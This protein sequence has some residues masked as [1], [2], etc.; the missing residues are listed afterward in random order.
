[1]LQSPAFSNQLLG[2]RDFVVLFPQGWGRWGNG[3]KSELLHTENWWWKWGYF[4]EFGG[5]KELPLELVQF[6]WEF[7][8][9]WWVV[10]MV[11][12]QQDE[13]RRSQTYSFNNNFLERTSGIT[14]EDNS[15]S[16]VPSCDVLGFH[17]ECLAK[18]IYHTISCNGSSHRIQ[19]ALRW[20][21][22]PFLPFSSSK[23]EK[24]QNHSEYWFL[25]S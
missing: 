17:F 18:H 4:S 22:I 8:W 24:F 16:P 5:F 6:Q 15:S 7:Y 3:K 2:R 10:N 13:P 12:I 23:P 20:N 1:M 9:K 11:F 21:R 19:S 25:L 14:S